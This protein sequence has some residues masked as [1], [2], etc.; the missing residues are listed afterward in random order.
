MKPLLYLLPLLL[1]GCSPADPFDQ[2]YDQITTDGLAAH[3][4][5]L[6]SD[7]FGGRAP[8]SAGEEKTLSYLEQELRA[9]GF[10]PGNGSSFRQPVMLHSITPAPADLFIDDERYAYDKDQVTISH[11]FKDHVALTEAELVFVGYGINAPELNWNDY[12]GLDV[13]GK[14]V[15]VLVND[16]DFEN[17]ASQQFGGK[18]MTYYGRWTYKYEEAARQGAAGALIVHEDEPASYGWNVVVN[19]RS[20][21]QLGRPR[22]PTEPLLQVEGWLTRAAAERLFEQARQNFTDLKARAMQGPTAL[23]LGLSASIDLQNELATTVSSNLVA[24]LPGRE[25]PEERIIYTA[26]WDHLGTKDGLIYNGALDNASGTAGLLQIARAFASLPERPARSVTLIATTAEEQGLI[27]SEHYAAEPLYP[28]AKTVAVFNMDSLNVLGR[29]KELTVVGLGKSQVEDYLARAAERQGRVLAAE[30]RPERGGYFRSDHFPFALKGVPAVY[31]GGGVTPVDE[32][33]AKY[34]A[35]ME[36]HVASCYHEACD[37][38]RDDWD[39]SGAVEDLQ[40]L[41]DAGYQLVTSN[42]W[43]QWSASA[44]FKRP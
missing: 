3:I 34:R 20:G 17:P 18:A 41:F 43:P 35:L 12:A 24:T 33:T 4:K 13:K 31:A 7:D 5:V 6:A 40:L 21:P 39:L 25:R 32:R 16:P 30:S 29:V 19:G 2:A 9:L 27:G 11:Q 36:K 10:E 37:K 42:D 14:V 15:V 8:A 1:V 26:H 44:E 22:Q 23:P 28:L 38:F